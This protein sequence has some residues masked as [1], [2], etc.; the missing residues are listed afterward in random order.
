MTTKM[1][2]IIAGGRDFRDYNLMKS[3][4]DKILSNVKLKW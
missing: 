2:I 1:R 4:M 3:K